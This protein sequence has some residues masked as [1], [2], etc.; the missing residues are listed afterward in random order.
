MPN[1]LPRPRLVE[2]KR[3]ILDGVPTYKFR[4]PDCG[5]WGF[6]D[7]EQAQGLVSSVCPVCGFHETVQISKEDE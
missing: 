7:D 4:C 2:A 6:V 5:T 3:V 1:D